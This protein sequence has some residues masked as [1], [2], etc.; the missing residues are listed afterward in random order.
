MGITTKER[1]ELR[2]ELVGQGYSW[3]FID[4][5]HSKITLYRHAATMTP[6]GD[7]VSSVGTAVKG[8]PSTPD[9]ALRKAKLGMLPYPPSESCT[10]EWCANGKPKSQDIPV[11]EKE[12]DSQLVKLKCSKCSYFTA[13][14]SKAG[15][16]AGLRA[17]SKVHK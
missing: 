5:P 3:E 15:A 4:E 2:K 1:T 14:S 8:L 12:D 6:S 13:S 9:Y 17:H 10:C 16:L 11:P 7:I